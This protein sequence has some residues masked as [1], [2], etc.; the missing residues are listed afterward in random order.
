MCFTVYCSE[1][2]M[3]L[4]AVSENECSYVILCVS[5][6]DVDDST[7]SLV[8]FHEIVNLPTYTNYR[9]P[10]FFNYIFWQY[11]CFNIQKLSLIKNQRNDIGFLYPIKSNFYLQA[12]SRSNFSYN[13][14]HT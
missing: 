14:K 2:K 13:F 8:S 3:I 5:K 12:I 4:P 1:P 6:M 7:E 9:T 11:L 10:E